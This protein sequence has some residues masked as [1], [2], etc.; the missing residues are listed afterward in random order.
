VK[1]VPYLA[2]EEQ[3]EEVPYEECVEVGLK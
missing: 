2:P 3:C 1:E